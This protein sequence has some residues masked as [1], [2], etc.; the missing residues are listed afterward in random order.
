MPR[1]VSEHFCIRWDFCISVFSLSI[2]LLQCLM[3]LAV[4]LPQEPNKSQ[5]TNTYWIHHVIYTS[6]PQGEEITQ[7]NTSKYNPTGNGEIRA[8]CQTCCWSLSI[9]YSSFHHIQPY[10]HLCQI[11]VLFLL[12]CHLYFRFLF[13][14]TEFSFVRGLVD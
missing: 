3:H 13:G 8:D 4:D 2:F 9:T 1:K 5:A 6:V 12:C 10:S 14:G 7:P 11:Y